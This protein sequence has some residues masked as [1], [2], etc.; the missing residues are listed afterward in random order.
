M[1]SELVLP[2]WLIDMTA[3]ADERL[4]ARARIDQ[5]AWF[6]EFDDKR[7]GR[8]PPC[9]SCGQDMPKD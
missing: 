7:N 1:S 8:V 6:Q 5:P 2:Q 9:K 4:S 3:E